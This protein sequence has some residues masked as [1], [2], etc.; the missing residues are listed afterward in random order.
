[1]L[2]V[3]KDWYD[4]EIIDDERLHRLDPGEDIQVQLF[5]YFTTDK[6]TFHHAR[7]F[8]EVDK[9]DETG[10]RRTH[11]ACD[12]WPITVPDA[13]DLLALDNEQAKAKLRDKIDHVLAL[14]TQHQYME[15][16]NA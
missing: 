11:Y 4:D 3:H 10:E 7:L 16:H 13:L 12:G 5:T 1:M 9:R 14:P 6:D 2:K 15:N 8:I